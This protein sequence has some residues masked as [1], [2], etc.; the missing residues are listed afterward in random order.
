MAS[1]RTVVI[2]LLVLALPAQGAAAATMALC[3]LS[4][5]GWA[6]AE[7]G[8]DHEQAEPGRLALTPCHGAA[9]PRQTRIPAQAHA[10]VRA[11]AGSDTAPIED[12]ALKLAQADLHNCSACAACSATAA[13]ITACIKVPEAT[14]SRAVGPAT[15]AP[16][17]RFASEGPDRP[18]RGLLV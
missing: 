10:D 18:P 9:H 15:A 11:T 12:P 16:V 7:Q 14:A 17:E 4:H 13:I 2:W 8:V 6:T 3:Q 1:F 5:P